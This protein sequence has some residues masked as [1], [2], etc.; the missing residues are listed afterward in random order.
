MYAIVRSGGKQLRVSPGDS[1]W[2]ERLSGEVGET[3]ALRDVLL[4]GGD[5]PPRIGAPQVPGA[6]V[7]GTIAG[8][9]R[10]EKIIVFKMKRRKNYRRRSGHRQDYTQLRIE[11]IEGSE[12]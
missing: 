3:V 2:V 12:V 4:V 9:G 11:R 7:H 10:G 1:V 8:H 5:G 6:V